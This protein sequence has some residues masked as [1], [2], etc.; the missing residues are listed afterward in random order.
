[1]QQLSSADGTV[2]READSTPPETAGGGVRAD[3]GTANAAVGTGGNELIIH[4]RLFARAK[5]LAGTDRCELRLSQPATTLGDL[6]A[7]LLQCFPDLIP[8]G[9]R[10]LAAVDTDYAADSLPLKS[11]VE[12]AFFPPVSGG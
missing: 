8:L 12:V 9:P 6:R 4:V 7:L 11:G 3:A 10:L 2:G 1:M 5:D